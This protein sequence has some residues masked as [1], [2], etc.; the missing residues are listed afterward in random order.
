MAGTQIMVERPQ[1]DKIINAA[2]FVKIIKIFKINIIKNIK[3]QDQQIVYNAATFVVR[4][5]RYESGRVTEKYLEFKYSVLERDDKFSQ[6][7]RPLF[8]HF[9]SLLTFDTLGKDRQNKGDSSRVHRTG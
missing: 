6:Q 5:A 8:C 3:H 7:F 1:A 2:T 4:R 9:V